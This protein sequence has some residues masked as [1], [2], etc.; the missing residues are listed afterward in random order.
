MANIIFI[1]LRAVTFVFLSSLSNSIFWPSRTWQYSHSTPRDAVMNC[2]EGNTRSAGT[3]FRAWMFLNCSS[4]SLGAAGGCGA[5]LWAVAPA[6]ASPV[7]RANPQKTMVTLR[8]FEIILSP[9]NVNFSRKSVSESGPRPLERKS[10]R[11]SSG[12]EIAAFGECGNA[13]GGAES[14]RLDGHGGLA[15]AGRDQ[16]AAV[17]EK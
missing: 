1:I 8:S 16:T 12:R 10:R 7:P 2:M 5:L 6:M 13:V 4:A 9:L 11:R 14:Q 15:A 3:P 17:T